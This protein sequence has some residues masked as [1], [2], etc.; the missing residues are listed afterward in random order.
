M[1]MDKE[2]LFVL[3]NNR[4]NNKKQIKNSDFAMKFKILCVFL[5]LITQIVE[6]FCFEILNQKSNH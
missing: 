5:C 3:Q 4:Y 1:D 2:N 6:G